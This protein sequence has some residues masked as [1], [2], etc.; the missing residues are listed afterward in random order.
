MSFFDDETT[1]AMIQT[2][3]ANNTGDYTPEEGG[4][5]VTIDADFRN[6][7]EA[8][9]LLGIEVRNSHPLAFVV[10]SDLTGTVIGGTLLTKGVTYKITG[11]DPDGEGQTMLELS[12][13]AP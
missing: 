12:Q 7:Y 8:S 6:A 10:T 13:D 4:A 3:G 5:A 1:R 11:Q 9:I 2:T